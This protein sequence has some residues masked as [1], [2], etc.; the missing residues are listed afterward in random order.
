[1]IYAKRSLSIDICLILF[2]LSLYLE[3]WD[4]PIFTSFLL[5]S[6]LQIIFLLIC[7]LTWLK[8]KIAVRLVRDRSVYILTGFVFYFFIVNIVSSLYFHGEEVIHP[9][10]LA[11]YL[12]FLSL[13]WY[14]SIYPSRINM[15]AKINMVVINLLFIL[16]LSG[17]GV[18]Y[19]QD[20]VLGENRLL[21]FGIN[22]NGLSLY[23][24]LSVVS[25]LHLL[26]QSPKALSKVFPALSLVLGIGVITMAGS[27]GG[28]IF[29][30][31]SIVIILGMRLRNKKGSILL[32]LIALLVIVS[33]GYEYL[34]S[35]PVFYN[36]INSGDDITSG[37]LRLFKRGIEVFIE[38]PIFG[39]GMSGYDYYMDLYFGEVRPTHNGYIDIA[40]YTGLVGL[41]VFLSYLYRQGKEL[42]VHVSNKMFPASFAIFVIFMLNFSKDGGVLFAKFTW[43]YIAIITSLAG[44]M[45]HYKSDK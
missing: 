15:L 12:T 19:G 42:W 3:N 36:R 8:G 18:S 28:L 13:A 17:F 31:A 10:L 34:I 41:V 45:N 20:F 44:Y 24:V 16:A 1:M 37:R 35:T 11:N 2:F 29:L 23:A 33:L 22:P 25:S 30:L 27:N 21:I 40:A 14:L 32:A 5:T 9:A 39:S 38:H 6:K 43:V 4:I 26:F 7:I